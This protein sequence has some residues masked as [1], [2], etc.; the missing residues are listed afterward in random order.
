[1]PGA[2]YA[3]VPVTRRS[4]RHIRQ[5]H[6]NKTATHGE[7]IGAWYAAWRAFSPRH[8]HQQQY[9]SKQRHQQRLARNQRVGSAHSAINIAHIYQRHGGDDTAR[10][11]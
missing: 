2:A 6:I 7:N 11:V 8:S 1:M 3:G 9:H 4:A 5:Q 10:R